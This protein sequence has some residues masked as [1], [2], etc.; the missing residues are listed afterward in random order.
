MSCDACGLNMRQPLAC[1]PQLA[2]GAVGERANLLRLQ[3]A[4]Q[5]TPVHRDLL[6]DGDIGHRAVPVSPHI[7]QTRRRFGQRQRVTIPT[8]PL[9]HDLDIISRTG[10]NCPPSDPAIIQHTQGML[11][12]A[13]AQNAFRRISVPDIRAR[14]ILLYLFGRDRAVRS[15]P[16]GRSLT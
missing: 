4:A 8:E 9:T 14:I 1:H 13:A 15:I 12:H 7:E 10:N 6:A 2:V 11:V 3:P 16:R 5:P